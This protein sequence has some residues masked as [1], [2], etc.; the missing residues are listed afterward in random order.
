[1]SS[2]KTV[3]FSDRDRIRWSIRLSEGKWELFELAVRFGASSY[4][5]DVRALTRPSVQT[6]MFALRL[7]MPLVA[8]SADPPNHGFLRD[9]PENSYS[10]C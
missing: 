7:L 1:M 4:L 2:G 6:E 3:R 9:R 8:A 5:A 10:D